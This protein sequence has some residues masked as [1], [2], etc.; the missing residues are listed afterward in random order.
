MIAFVSIPTFDEARHACV[1]TSLLLSRLQPP[2]QF[3]MLKY[4]PKCQT[5]VSAIFLLV[6]SLTATADRLR[7]QDVQA[8]ECSVQLQQSD[9]Q[10]GTHYLHRASVHREKPPAAA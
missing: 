3:G 7:L 8:V 2:R 5:G 9:G 4:F 1:Q 10:L 6:V